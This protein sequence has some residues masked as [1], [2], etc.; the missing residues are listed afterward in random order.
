LSDFRGGAIDGAVKWFIR[1]KSAAAST[2]WAC[3]PKSVTT[4]T[5]IESFNARLRDEL[6]DCEIFYS[7]KEAKIL[8]ESWRRH[9]DAVLPPVPKR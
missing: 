6:L 1:L 7:L 9:Y 2:E 8:I 5:S 4:L 3:P